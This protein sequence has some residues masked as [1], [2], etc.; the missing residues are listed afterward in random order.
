M[1]LGVFALKPDGQTRATRLVQ[2]SI[3]REG[4]VRGS[5]YDLLSD[6]VHGI[7]G[8]VDKQALRI[9][10]AIG[11]SGKVVFQG[12]LGELTRPEARVTAYFPDGKTAAWR[13]VQVKQVPGL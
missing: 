12:P 1:P 7:Q 4:V 5:H 11:E 3:S 13:M 9:A 10:F 8:A 2:L 6:D